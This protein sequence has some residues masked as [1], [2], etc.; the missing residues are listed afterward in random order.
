MKQI[1]LL[2]ANGMSTSMLV[3][4]MEEAARE[5]NYDC[6]IEAHSIDDITDYADVDVILLGPQVKFQLGKVKSLVNCP[7]DVIEMTTYG[8]MNGKAAL[9]FAKNLMEG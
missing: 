2:C 7:I 4:K 3:K 1:V 9:T 6:T 8:T 5:E